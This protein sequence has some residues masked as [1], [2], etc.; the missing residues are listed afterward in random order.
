MPRPRWRWSGRGCL[1]DVEESPELRQLALGN[2]GPLPKLL[3]DSRGIVVDGLAGAREGPHEP[4][5]LEIGLALRGAAGQFHRGRQEAAVE[6]DVAADRAADE[7]LP[8][9]GR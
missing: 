2:V 4:A 3:V 6:L 1:P 5:R 8:V 7:T 9:G